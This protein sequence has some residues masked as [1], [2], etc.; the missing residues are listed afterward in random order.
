MS[1]P[2]VPPS[3]LSRWTDWSRR[4]A[5]VAIIPAIVLAAAPFLAGI[6]AWAD[7]VGQFLLQGAAFSAALAVALVALRR[8]GLAI[9]AV[10]GLGAQLWVLTHYAGL[11]PAMAS[12]LMAGP[13]VL[14]LNVWGRSRAYD[15]VMDLV[16]RE[17]PDI[18]VLIEVTKE[19]R[20]AL[21]PLE[22]D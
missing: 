7:L 19:W 20:R 2:E 16:R 17:S 15:E 14:A 11:K 6:S 21:R 8:R 13:K 4:H 9:V 3:R 5:I 12:P 1:T 10:A 22:R 18:V